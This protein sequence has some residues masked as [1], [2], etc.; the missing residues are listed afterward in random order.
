V[1]NLA[2][3]GSKWLTFEPKRLEI[4]FNLEDFGEKSLPFHRDF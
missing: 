2:E 1:A 3:P 4:A